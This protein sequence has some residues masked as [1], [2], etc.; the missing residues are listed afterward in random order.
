MLKAAK[1]NRFGK[2]NKKHH[3]LLCLAC[4]NMPKLVKNS[5]KADSSCAGPYGIWL[6][7]SQGAK[8]QRLSMLMRACATT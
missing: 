1:E 5:V 8:D 2:K 7:W 4:S 3:V 6:I